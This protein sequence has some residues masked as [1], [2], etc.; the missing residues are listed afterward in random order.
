MDL[1]SIGSA[2]LLIVDIYAIVMIMQSYAK[3]PKKYSGPFL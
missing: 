1:T 2:L 3:T